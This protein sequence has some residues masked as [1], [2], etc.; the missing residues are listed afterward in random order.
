MPIL[1]LC[2]RGA[3]CDMLKQTP[4]LG[5]AVN[6]LQ[7][8]MTESDAVCIVGQNSSG[9]ADAC[10]DGNVL[11]APAGIISYEPDELMISLYAGSTIADINVALQTAHQRILIPEIGTIGEHQGRNVVQPKRCMVATGEI[12]GDEIG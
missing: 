5:S 11:Q 1:H 2:L 12:G 10:A 9:V 6:D 3:G 7:Q 4:N 8:Q